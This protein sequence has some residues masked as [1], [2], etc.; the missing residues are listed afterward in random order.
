MVILLEQDKIYAKKP[1]KCGAITRHLRR[2]MC[3][4][5]YVKFLHSKVYSRRKL[6]VPDSDVKDLMTRVMNEPEMLIL[7]TREIEKRRGQFR[8]AYYK[9]KAR[10]A[11]PRIMDYFAKHQSAY[12]SELSEA[13]NLNPRTVILACNMLEEEG[14]LEPTRSK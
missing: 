3:Y 2:G 7:L 4:K 1:C 10:E 9:H 5:C 6:D 11:K 8:R 14:K 13:L 12:I